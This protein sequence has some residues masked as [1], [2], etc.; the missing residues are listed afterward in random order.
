MSIPQILAIFRARIWT[1]IVFTLVTLVASVV[2]L[3]FLPRRYDATAQIYFRLAD[4]DPATNEQVPGQ[5]IRNFLQTQMETMRSAG[6]GI[7][8]VE[9]LGLAKDPAWQE[10][11]RKSTDGA[12]DINRWIAGGISGGLRIDRVGSSDIIA[13]TYRDRDPKRAALYANAYVTAYIK[14]EIDLRASPARDL[15]QWYEERLVPLRE[16]LAELGSKRSQLRHEAGLV[17]RDDIKNS[18]ND[19]VTKLSAE[20]TAVRLEL[21]QAKVALELLQSNP[22]QLSETDEMRQLRR[23]MT[24]LDSE[25]A[26][27]LRVVGPDHMR[28]KTLRLNRAGLEEQMSN[29]V[30]RASA[31]AI[32]A[33]Q[34]RIETGERRLQEVRVSLQEGEER[35]HSQAGNK[36]FAALDREMEGLKAQIGQIIERRER[37]ELIG[38]VQQSLASRLIEASEPTTPAFPRPL[39]IMGFALGLGIPFGFA[40]GFLREMFDRRVRHVDDISAFTELSTLAVVPIDRKSRLAA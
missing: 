33:A 14:K 30:K 23:Q 25:I 20:A 28:I 39:L 26:R 8:V 1:T 9:V 18:S 19:E 3:Q 37:L 17:E 32:A 15:F 7:K 10:A 2:A 36:T 31:E 16:R 22:S 4:R 12:G 34:R 38:S 21:I 29:V 24:D 27:A 6:V 40:F 11:F 5:V 35:A 13:V